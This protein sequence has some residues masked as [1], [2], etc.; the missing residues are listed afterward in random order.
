VNVNDIFS[1]AAKECAVN[2]FLHELKNAKA[3]LKAIKEPSCYD[4]KNHGDFWNC[5]KKP[6]ISD[7][8]LANF[9]STDSHLANIGR[10]SD[11]V[12]EIESQLGQVAL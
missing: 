7:K 10:Q 4:C 5:P 2:T 9:E 8:C 1:S 3:A 12:A 11:V 6:K